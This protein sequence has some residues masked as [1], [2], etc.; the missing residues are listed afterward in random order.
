MA[1]NPEQ[2]LAGQNRNWADLMGAYRFFNNASVEPAAIAQ[3]HWQLTRQR[4]RQHRLVLCVQDTSEMDYSDYRGKKGLGSIN[5]ENG[6]GFLQHTV[7]AVLP[8][9]Q[10]LGA[11]H[12]RWKM[13]VDVPK[14]E[15]RRQRRARWN[16][17]QFWA[18]AVEAVGPP[19]DK[20]RFLTVCDRGGDSFGT[21]QACATMNHGFLIRAQHDR[22]V[23]SEEG[24]P[25]VRLWDWME[26]QPPLKKVQVKVEARYAQRVRNK[27]LSIKHQPARIVTVEVRSA[28]VLLDAPKGDH[29]HP[30]PRQV[31]VVHAREI[32]APRDVSEPIDWML[33]SS[34]PVATARQALRLIGL[35]RRRW[36]I[37]E[38]HKVQKS[39][40]NLEHSQLEDAQA[41][42]RL[43]ALVGV[44]AVRMLWLRDLASL[45]LSN[46]KPAS[47]QCPTDSDPPGALQKIMPPLWIKLAAHLAGIDQPEKLTAQQF[48]RVIASRGGWLGRKHDH[49]PGWKVLWRGW[50]ELALLVQ[51]A[52]LL[53]RTS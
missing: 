8:G 3:P 35:Y 32:N 52:E 6:Q 24:K 48:W 41:L 38:Y 45:H 44:L 4:C 16:E 7:L 47:G 13:R 34:E 42:R 43:A 50:H 9:G 36:V 11:L 29:R 15:T 21:M 25:A 27:G 18:D 37:E 12:Q 46:T 2:S 39:G 14:G 53:L 30:Q 1:G 23:V 28:T 49:R 19:P 20:T 5:R 31:N 22:C 33:L 51:G 10:L 26:R 40:C 17:G